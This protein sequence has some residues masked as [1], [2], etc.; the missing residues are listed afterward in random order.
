MI[1]L[2]SLVGPIVNKFVDRIPNGNERARAKEALEKELV[3]AANSVMLAQTEIN[4]AE[5]QHKS[6]FVAGWR[7]F[8]GWVCGVGIAWS[9]V[10]QPVAQWAMIAWGDGTELPTIDTS[11]LMELVTAMLGMS[12]LRTFEKMRGVA[13]RK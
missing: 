3:D 12:G 2:A 1:G 13:R 5:A 10:V 7:P 9:M 11:Y 4:A 8:I 6:I